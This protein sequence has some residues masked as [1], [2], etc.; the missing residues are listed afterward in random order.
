[1]GTSRESGRFVDSP[2]TPLSL[3]PM[4]TVPLAP[5]AD[6]AARLARGEHHDPHSILG[7]H[8]TAAGGTV[9]RAFHPDATAAALVAR[10]GGTAP[11]EPIGGGL[12]AATVPGLAPGDLAYRIRFGFP[13]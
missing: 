2:P 12:W 1:M 9:I 7:A 5:A 11:M 6:E 4:T 13:D 10:D 3:A 8:P